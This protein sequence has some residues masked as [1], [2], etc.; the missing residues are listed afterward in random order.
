MYNQVDSRQF[1]I[2]LNIAQR[3]NPLI[4]DMV[5]LYTPIEYSNMRC[6]LSR[7]NA[8]GYAIKDGDLVSVFSLVKGRGTD[9]VISAKKSGANRLDCFDGYL[10]SLYSKLAFKE[11]KRELNWVV[12]EPDVVYMQLI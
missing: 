10:V 9:L 8:S 1:Y 3:K 2:A 7:D 4:K 5:H 11:Y 12:G 6:Y